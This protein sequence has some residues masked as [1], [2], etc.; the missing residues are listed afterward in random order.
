MTCKTLAQDIT[1][2]LGATSAESSDLF[3]FARNGQAYNIPFQSMISSMGVT[4]IIEPVGAVTSVSILNQP[5]TGYNYIRGIEASRGIFA[6]VSAEG[7]VTIRTDF[8]NGAGGSAI[9]ADLT[10]NQVKFK[11]LV[12]GVNT[13]ITETADNLTID[14]AESD[15]L[16]F[17]KVIRSVTDFDDPLRS[18]VQYFIDGEVILSS[19]ALNVTAGGVSIAGLGFGISKLTSTAPSY[20]MFNSASCG[21]IFIDRLDI[22]VSGVGSRVF[23]VVD[24]DGSHTIELTVLNFDNCTSIGEYAGFRQA[25]EFNTGRFG[26]TPEL[27]LSGS[28]GGCRV[29]TS[30][31]RGISN[32]TTLF[33][34]GTALTFTGRFITDINA[35][36][37]ATGALFDFSAANFTNDESMIINNAYVT[38]ADALDASDTTLYPNL[39]HQDIK[40]N[41]AGNTG[42]PNTVKYIKSTC[43]AEVV[44]ALSAESVG[45]FL[46]LLGTFT[47]D[48]GVH[49]DMPNNGEF[50]LLSGNGIYNITGNVQIKATAADIVTVRVMLSQDNGATY[51]TEVNRIQLETPNFTGANDFG[52][53]SLSL[54][55]DL[56]KN[57]RV[58]LEVANATAARDVTM[59]AQSF[60]ILTGA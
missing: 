49:F 58:R 50:R 27:T 22:E 44:T 30:I 9:I 28:M 46:P 42:I 10:A 55:Q 52:T 59:L 45:D 13:T 5:A 6:G 40:S 16:T 35:D 36:M 1:Q 38:R 25:L 17:Q 8:V 20:T 14:V 3:V 26:G 37:A 21:D 34:A 31:V 11:S 33:K 29:T 48:I 15:P 57:S 18:D 39:N 56:K 12:G 19:T 51:P 24:S 32:G 47:V 53:Y 23:D 4:G 43:T 60:V 54:I 7:G 41:W 2:A